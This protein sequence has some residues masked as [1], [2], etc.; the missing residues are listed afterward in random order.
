M[1]DLS[2]S[3]SSRLNAASLRPQVSAGNIAKIVDTG[4][5]PNADASSTAA[6]PPAARVD[7]VTVTGAGTAATIAPTSPSY[8]TRNDPAAPSADKNGPAAAPNVDL[9]SAAVQ[10]IAASNAA[11][12]DAKAIQAGSSAIR[13]ILDIKV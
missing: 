3:A 1:S 10:Q 9:A 12:A 7:R 11:A 8:V 2:I 6:A 5:P 13:G 4:P